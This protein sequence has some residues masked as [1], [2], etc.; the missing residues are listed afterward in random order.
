MASEPIQVIECSGTPRHMGQQYG[1][2]A[3]EAI[4]HNV[5]FFSKSWHEEACK[6]QMGSTRR[7]L[8]R[9]LPDIVEEIEGIG[10]GAGVPSDRILF[11]NHVATLGDDWI[12][13]CTPLAVADGP[14]GP[15][16]AKNNDG[17]TSEQPPFA[18]GGGSRYLYV[19]RRTA[20]D[21]GIPMLQVTYSG[22][23]SGLDALNAAG[24]A[25]MH[26]S[27]GSKF[28][29]SGPRVDVRLWVYHLMSTCACTTEFIEGMFQ[30]NLT[31]K[32][33]SIAVGDRSGDTAVVEAAVPL[34]AYRDRGRPFVYS[35]NLYTSD[36]LQDADMR[37]PALKP[38]SY[39]RT[40]YLRWVEENCPPKSLAD[41]QA[42]LS[43]HEPWAPCRH[44]GAHVSHT[45][46][47]AIA[48]PQSNRLLVTN[49]APCQA[50]YQEFDVE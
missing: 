8:E 5:E 17:G 22:W 34:V 37:T 41:M 9:E 30:G 25:N 43:C 19:V 11:M 4:Q 16:V 50:D 26:G 45:E 38:I 13:E 12:D 29:K 39:Y 24:L 40:G 44:G 47:S 48:L 46:W 20:P 15:I 23:L 14:D 3:R 32:G 28:D 36:A 31:G 27:V 42:L 1:E 35:T 18:T 33:F 10:E 6:G 2:Q 21:Q 7:V 49:D